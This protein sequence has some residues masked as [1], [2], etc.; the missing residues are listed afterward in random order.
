MNIKL[1]K[2]STIANSPIFK[3]VT[4]GDLA[5][6]VGMFVVGLA[7]LRTPLFAWNF[8]AILG[9]IALCSL[10]VGK[11]PT[12]RSV[13]ANIYGIVFKKPIKMVVSDQA[14]LT[15]IGHGIKEVIFVDGLDTPAFKMSDGLYAL[16][17]NITSGITQWSTD[18]DLT[19]QALAMKTLFN[20]MEGGEKLG[21][22]MKDD[23][24]TGMLSLLHH[25]DSVEKFSGDDLKKLSDHRKSFLHNAA[26][27][28]AG[29]SVQ[30]YAILYVKPKNVTRVKNSLDRA[31]RIIRPAT[32]PA[33]ILLSA[34]GLEGGVMING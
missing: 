32:R 25:L 17:Y 30:Q 8:L 21:L 18:D 10:I 28:E 31:S 5:M 9:Y 23:N 6:Y 20:I 2:S 12:G 14:T 1:V 15:S 7:L 27:S 22:V 11:T 34:M 19:R 33:D 13:F 3:S 4:A 29:I 16:V 26:T 24:D